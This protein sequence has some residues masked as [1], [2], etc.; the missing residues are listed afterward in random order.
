MTAS[1]VEDLV[2][3][4]SFYAICRTHGGSARAFSRFVGFVVQ[5]GRGHRHF[6]AL[7]AIRRIKKGCRVH[8]T[9]D[10]YEE[11]YKWAQNRVA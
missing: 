10:L 8:R 11:S 4:W 7:C 6:G 5:D 9:F 3:A 1:F 2:G